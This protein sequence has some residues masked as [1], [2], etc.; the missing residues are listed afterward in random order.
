M[1]RQFQPTGVS[2]EVVINNQSNHSISLNLKDVRVNIHL[3][4][5]IAALVL[6]LPFTANSEVAIAPGKQWSKRLQT[7]TIQADTVEYRLT[8][9]LL[10]GQSAIE[11][12]RSVVL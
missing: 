5:G 2:F 6:A 8:L 4:S 9:K 1:L 12:Q 11:Y 10:D 3:D 7:M